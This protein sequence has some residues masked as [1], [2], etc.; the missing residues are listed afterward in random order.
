MVIFLPILNFFQISCKRGKVH[1]L[2]S[3]TVS[4]CADD[5]N[6]STQGKTWT[7]IQDCLNTDLENVDQWLISNKLTFNKKQT[8]Y[9]IVGSRQ[10]MSN[11]TTKPKI[12]LGDSAIERVTKAKTLGVIIDENLSWNDQIQ[13]IV[14]KASKV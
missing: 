3:S 4:M 9:M 11:I 7:E 1:C 13:N 2:S 8:E 6:I 10:R 14:T 12:V 5:T